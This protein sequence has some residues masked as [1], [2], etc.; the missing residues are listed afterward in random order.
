MKKCF[1][2]LVYKITGTLIAGPYEFEFESATT[3][4]MFESVLNDL[5]HIPFIPN[6]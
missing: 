3:S 2:T 5:S 6:L 1:L 4:H